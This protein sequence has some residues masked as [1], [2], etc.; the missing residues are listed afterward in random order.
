MTELPQ[1]M[2]K[3]LEA[4]YSFGAQHGLQKE[5]DEIRDMKIQSAVLFDTRILICDL[6]L[7]SPRT[8]KEIG[9]TDFG[10]QAIN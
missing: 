6:F 5:I 3:A 9:L 2:T 7:S 4:A 10:L 8:L 1:K